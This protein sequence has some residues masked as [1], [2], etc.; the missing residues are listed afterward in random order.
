MNSQLILSSIFAGV[1]PVLSLLLLVF[2]FSIFI[3]FFNLFIRKRSKSQLFNNTNFE[4]VRLLNKQE[5]KVYEALVETI[6]IQ[7]GNQYKV[8]AQVSLGEIL[9]N[10]DRSSFN[11][12]N[13]KRVDF[14]IVNS[15]YM[16]IAAIEYHGGGHFRG[17]YQERDEIKQQAVEYAGL[18]YHA[19]FEHN[20]DNIY[21]HI[22]TVIVPLLSAQKPKKA[23]NH[24]KNQRVEPTF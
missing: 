7:S 2:A 21:E 20:L 6:Q 8:F 18:V 3:I 14:C 22:H 5:V 15:D 11:R 19:I 10:Y 13:Q 23:R 1:K 12:I 16:P 17:N 9:K 24:D 4:A